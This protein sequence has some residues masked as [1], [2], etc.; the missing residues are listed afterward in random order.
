MKER[1]FSYLMVLHQPSADSAKNS[2]SQA[3]KMGICVV[4]QI[5]HRA[6]EILA[7]PSEAERL[8]EQGGFSFYS[9]KAISQEHTK[10]FD[11][12]LLAMVKTWNEKF[13]GSYMKIKKDKSKKGLKWQNENMNEP[14]PFSLVDPDML[15][16]EFLGTGKKGKRKGFDE[17]NLKPAL[18]IDIEKPGPKEIELIREFF[19]KNIKDEKWAYHLLGIFYRSPVKYRKYFLDPKVLDWLIEIIRHMFLADEPECLKMHDRN[20]VGIIFVESSRP[21]G[22]VFSNSDRAV[23]ENEI[24]SGLSFLAQEHP[25]RRLVWIYDVQHVQ[26]DVANQANSRDT[27]DSYWR[28]PAIQAAVFEGHTF[29]A[30]IA[31]IDAYRNAMR[32][33]H[34][35]QH[36][37]VIFVSAF[38][39]NWHAYSSGRRFIAMGPHGDDWGGWGV[40]TVNA[41]TAHE[42]CH[43]FGAADEYD[44]SGTPCNSCG[45]NH[46][47]ELI[48]NGNCEMCAEPHEECIMDD[49][50]L[51]L[52]NYT[53]A[54]IGWSDI[55]VELWTDT[56]F[57]SGTDDNVKLDIGYNTFNLDTRHNDR[58]RGNRDGY[59]IWAG[60]NLRRDVIKRILIRKESDGLSGGW[61]LA[62]VKVYHDGEIICDRS[63]HAWLE[64]HKCWYLACS[65]DN[66]LVNTLNLTVSTAD[67]RWAGTDDDVTLEMA[68]RTWD[69]D[70]DADDFE[71]NS[72]RSY[73][74]DP[75]TGMNAGDLHSLTIRKSPDG[76]AGGWKLKG[77]K[78]KV[79]GIDIYNNQAINQWLEDD[80]RTFS[81]EI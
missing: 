45:G 28:N 38:G 16:N 37:T 17:K 61:K 24:R 8:F 76:S 32:A 56:D 13:S 26:I 36:A 53:R 18:K 57:R 19:E 58:E 29:T 10:D 77:L 51:N 60:G 59:A 43:Q 5:G 2:C 4:A 44:G 80:H 68:G 7:S 70:S 27:D 23:I 39:M 78:L 11:P 31:G 66:S 55:F 47:C 54:H 3:Q 52:C 69:I 63:P 15:F 34:G 14:L 46:G 12:E 9:R 81:D 41:I 21:R 71:R 6:I 48:P 49:N 30:D 65:F 33:H 42:M 20:S 1:M 79:N 35:S 64:D 72:T 74:L 73:E 62:R 22:P 67:V 25:T 40:E 75:K 50:D